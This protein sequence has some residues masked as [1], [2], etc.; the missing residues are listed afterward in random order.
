MDYAAILKCTTAIISM[1]NNMDSTWEDKALKQLECAKTY[2][3]ET[4][5]NDG[6]VRQALQHM[7]T[8]IS[9]LDP[10][11]MIKAE[12][13]IDKYNDLCALIAYTHHKLGDSEN[14][15]D[16]WIG[17]VNILNY[18]PILLKEFNTNKYEKLVKRYHQNK[19]ADE[20]ANERFYEITHNPFEML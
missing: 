16:F 17:K 18:P 7:E 11:P 5:P 13:R 15:V 8:A 1:M 9:F 12:S 6:L 10:Y 3:N 20:E 2:L 4:N 19:R 14:I